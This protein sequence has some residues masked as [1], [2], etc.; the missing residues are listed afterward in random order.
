MEKTV[1]AFLERQ[2]ANKDLTHEAAGRVTA[3][4]EAG[5]DT[6]GAAVVASAGGGAANSASGESNLVILLGSRGS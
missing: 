4:H 6:D 5:E 3:V 1:S 2:L